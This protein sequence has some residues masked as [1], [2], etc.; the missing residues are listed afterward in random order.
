MGGSAFAEIGAD[1]AEMSWTN[2]KW[3]GARRRRSTHPCHLEYLY[4]QGGEVIKKI[5][6]IHPFDSAMVK[7][8]IV[9]KCE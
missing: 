1:A 3:Q 7:W 8:R 9:V 5:D 2:L 6:N 4:N